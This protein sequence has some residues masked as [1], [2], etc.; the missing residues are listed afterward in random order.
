MME[1]VGHQVVK[2]RRISHGPFNLGKL[3]PGQM[4]QLTEKEFDKARRSVM[5]FEPR[6]DPAERR[7]SE[8][9]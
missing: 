2:L 7:D 3:K 4:R 1:E 8:K 5:E 9:A 6:L